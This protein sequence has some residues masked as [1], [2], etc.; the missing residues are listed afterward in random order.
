[1][2]EENKE[3]TQ[4]KRWTL[5]KVK[6]RCRT[7]YW[8]NFLLTASV[9]MLTLAL[10]G[11]AFFALTYSYAIDER[12]EQMQS[13]ATVVSHMVS[14]YMENGSLTGLR[15]L[16]DFASNV[17]D[18]EFLICNSDGNLLLTTDTTLVNR[19]LTVPQDVAEGA[20][21]DDTYA[22]RTTL[23]DIYEDTHFV[24]G[25]PIVSE[26]ATV[27]FVLAVTGARA[28]TTMWRTFIGLFFMTAVTVL[29]LSFVVS[30]WVS[31]RQSRPIHEMAEAT[32]R[33]AEGNFD[34]RMHNYEGVTEIS[35]LAESFNN[36]AD[37][38]QETERQRREFI[39]NVS[40]EL[41]TPLASMK[42][43]S[44]SLLSQ[45]GMPEEL[46]REFLVDITH[47]IERM[48]NIINDLLT[49][50]KLDK[51]TAEMNIVNISI[52]DLI[53]QLLKRL[54]PIAAE[55]NIELIYESFRPIM[56]DVDEVK[57]SI[58]LNN[59]I[60]NAIKYN[61]DDGWVRV[62]LNADHKFFYVKIEDSGVGI[63]EDVQDKIFDR[64]YRV[65]K[66]RSRD[67]GGTGLGLSLT[68]STVLLHRG[69]I[70]LHSKEKE[71]STFTVRI[72]LTYVV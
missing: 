66:A 25:V 14:S 21:S 11:S 17:T 57:L 29:L 52:N 65:D 64:F 46:Y 49:M 70:K 53:E 4:K 6:T 55:R 19:V 39:A 71:G 34:V 54:R 32:R 22:V 72:P 43:L 10:L 59:L 13:K 44:D 20:M 18:A 67:T 2:P 33:F 41:K 3:K 45:E 27:G 26:G 28:L 9:V 23:G 48:T 68:R 38:L 69:S 40:H 15:E 62:T 36:M 60:E 63:P 50:V 24:V 61:Y 12:S 37:S 8:Q 7:I 58:A 47:E 16:A 56:A 5:K 1:M 51:N 30:A 31:M 42:V 35:E